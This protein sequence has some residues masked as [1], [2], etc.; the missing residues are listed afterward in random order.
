MRWM[1]MTVLFLTAQMAWGDDPPPL[2]VAPPEPA[3][4]RTG[5]PMPEVPAPRPRAAGYHEKVVA[6]DDPLVT[7]RLF[8]P[9]RCAEAADAGP[10]C[11]LLV[12]QD[13]GGRPDIRPYLDWARRHGVIVVGIEKVSNGMKQ[14][15]KPRFQRGVFKDL[16][17]I[18]LPVH[19]HLRFTI[20]MSGGSADGERFTRHSPEAFAGLLLQGAGGIPVDRRRQHLAVAALFGTLDDW[21]SVDKV[22]ER[23]EL[24]RRQGQSVRVIFYPRMGH[25]WAPMEDQLAALTWL[26]RTT[27]LTNRFLSDQERVGYREAMLAQVEADAAIADPRAR[28]AACRDWV[29]VA[30]LA[31][32]PRWQAMGRAYVDAVLAVLEELDTAER[33]AR[34][35]LAAT[36]KPPFE[37]GL[38][39][40]QQRERF[41]AVLGSWDADPV[42]ADARRRQARLREIRGD[43]IDAGRDVAKLR[44]VIAAYVQVAQEAAGTP[45]AE[46]AEQMAAPLRDWIARN[47]DGGGI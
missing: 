40:P 13:P 38:I 43:E 24:A 11:P 9:D 19:R 12:M 20:G 28:I 21:V 34:W 29:H 45:W 23:A 37:F 32:A 27:R 31:D 15:D 18:G 14:H 46:L 41:E 42:V 36:E 2:D 39:G 1:M 17:A 7:Y 30:P 5:L 10:G 3:G 33:R 26:M 47:P 8:V 22:K 6:F 16:E 25:A 35:L 4:N 44:L